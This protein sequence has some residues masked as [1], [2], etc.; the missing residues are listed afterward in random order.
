M[1]SLSVMT[2]LPSL[3][4]RKR[5]MQN[6]GSLDGDPYIDTIMTLYKLYHHFLLGIGMFLVLRILVGSIPLPMVRVIDGVLS[7][8]ALG[9]NVEGLVIVL[10]TYNNLELKYIITTHL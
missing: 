2:L 10:C 4:R 9:S 7:V 6:H 5:R 3:N 8:L 1:A